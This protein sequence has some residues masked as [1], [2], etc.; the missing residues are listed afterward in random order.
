M[1]DHLDLTEQKILLDL[2]RESLI[3]SVKGA[4][5]PE[6]D[7][8]S[9]PEALRADGASFVTLTE[10]GDL[11]GCIGAL[12]AY[13]PLALDVQEHAMAAA[14]QDFRFP[15]VRPDELDQIE[16]EVSVLTPRTLL[17]YDNAQDLIKKLRPGVDGVVLEDGF[18]KATFLPQVWDQLPKPEQ[19]LAHLCQKM[20]ASPDLW[21]HKHLTVF[22]YQVQE[23]H[24]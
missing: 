23:F 1:S 16:I 6:L 9:L 22:I 18:R 13:Q 24:E 20:G 21:R 19:F 15:Q 11:R 12:Q 3:Q 14:L 4:P 8:K 7:L 17:D 10:F 2:A 5:L